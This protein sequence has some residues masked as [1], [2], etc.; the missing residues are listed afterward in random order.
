MK[1]HLVLLTCIAVVGQPLAA[2]GN[3]HDDRLSEAL[4]IAQ[5]IASVP[6]ARPLPA[7]MVRKCF[8]AVDDLLRRAPDAEG[9]DP[10]HEI[11]RNLEPL[12]QRGPNSRLEQ[13]G[14]LYLLEQTGFEADEAART[15]E[16]GTPLLTSGERDALRAAVLSCWNVGA[17]SDEAMNTTV[18]AFFQVQA[19]GTVDAGSIEIREPRIGGSDEA[20]SQ[21]FEAARRALLRC[22]ADGLGVPTGEYE[23]TFSPESVRIR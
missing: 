21:S 20:I 6:I 4:Q 2:F 5:R 22:G 14:L 13:F 8:V 7:E 9:A 3:E 19:D 15:D 17:L 10:L 11:A 12:C 1:L 23:L 18:T 16:F